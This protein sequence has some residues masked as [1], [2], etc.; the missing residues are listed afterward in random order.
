M[1]EFDAALLIVLA[2]FAGIGALR[3]AIAEGF[4]WLVWIAA[5]VLTWLFSDIV[6]AWFAPRVADALLRDMLASIV[7]FI[8]LFLA[9]SIASWVL[10]KFVFA[11]PLT[12][13]LRVFGALLGLM[14]GV[15]VILVLFVLAGLTAFPQQPWWRESS[16]API[17]QPWAQA[18]IARL[19]A[20]VARQF[21]YR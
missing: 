17:V 13:G 11:L 14:R 6:S 1:N 3:G 15:A 2:A 8:G 4:S 18:A 7:T 12:P 5:G 10:R 20:E 19:P 21:S 9:L 16:A